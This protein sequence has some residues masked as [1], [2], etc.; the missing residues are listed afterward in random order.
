LFW[1]LVFFQTHKKEK[2]FSP[3]PIFLYFPFPF[4][5]LGKCSFICK[6]PSFIN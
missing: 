2:E 6:F 4:E 1:L 3:P 5:P